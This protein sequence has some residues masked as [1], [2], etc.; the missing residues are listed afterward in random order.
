ML[1]NLGLVGAND[2]WA[3]GYYYSANV[4]HSLIEHWNGSAWTVFSS[5]TDTHFH[6]LNGV[7][8]VSANDV[9]A[10]GFSRVSATNSLST[11]LVK[12]W[13]PQ[14]ITPTVTPTIRSTS[15]A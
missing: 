14:C 5:D 15:T 8:A 7:A 6:T 9:W 2:L 1:K 3:V 4:S 10:V 12:H 13:T 11:T